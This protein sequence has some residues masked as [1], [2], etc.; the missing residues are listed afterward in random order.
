MGV[1]AVARLLVVAAVGLFPCPPP[2][3]PDS[4]VPQCLRHPRL[5]GEGK[6]CLEVR[7]EASGVSATH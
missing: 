3:P 5:A 7:R 2:S 1:G 4:G 6:S